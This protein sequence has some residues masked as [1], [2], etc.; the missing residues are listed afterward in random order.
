[1]EAVATDA[2]TPIEVIRQGVEESLLRNRMMKRSVEH[3]DLGNVLAKEFSRS[4]EC[5]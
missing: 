3:G 5:P 1:M 4:H 2:M